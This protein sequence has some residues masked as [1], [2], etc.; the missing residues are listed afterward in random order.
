MR[1]N[2]IKKRL[3]DDKKEILIMKNGI[4][5]K[6]LKIINRYL[7]YIYQQIYYKYIEK[8]LGSYILN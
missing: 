1:K 7:K 5:K 4:F 6:K 3:R 2:N 8:I